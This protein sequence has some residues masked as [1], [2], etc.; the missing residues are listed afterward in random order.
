VLRGPAIVV[1]LLAA[2]LLVWTAVLALPAA[3]RWFPS[4]VWQYG[5]VAFDVALAVALALLSLRWR[6]RLADAV[7]I[8][9]TGDAVLTLVEAIAFN[10]PRWSSALDVLVV[11]IAILA[12]AV[13]AVLLWNARAHKITPP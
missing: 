3:G 1:R 6:P 13:A 10:I 8:A 7:A 5:W 12:P 9:V 2:L 11:V 4:P